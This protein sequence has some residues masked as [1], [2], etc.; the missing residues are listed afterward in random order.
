MK[1][2]IAIALVLIVFGS[3]AV[4]AQTA[5]A[6]IA[7]DSSAQLLGVT[8]NNLTWSHTTSGL[9]RI[10]FVGVWVNDNPGNVVTGATYAGV[11][12]T[13]IGHHSFLG[14]G[15]FADYVFMLVNPAVGTNNVVVSLSSTTN[16][17][18]QSV[19]YTGD[20]LLVRPNRGS[21]ILI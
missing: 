15:A 7:F 6:A 10:L 18:V 19:S 9:N 20:C 1:K 3:F 13:L 16:I 4:Q 12:M 11:P 14:G 21:F 8:A 17:A 5:A 2:I